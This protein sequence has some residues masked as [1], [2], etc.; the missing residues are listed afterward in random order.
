MMEAL[1]EDNKGGDLARR[2]ANAGGGRGGADDSA[3]RG[4]V[5]ESMKEDNK[6]GDLAR[7]MANAA[8]G[9]HDGTDDSSFRG[10]LF[11]AL[12]KVVGI[13]S[14]GVEDEEH[15]EQ[16]G[17]VVFFHFSRLVVSTL[18]FLHSIF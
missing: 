2:M 6:G 13:S 12:A 5:K 15:E 9:V 14:N 4:M 1:K 17:F 10:R 8:G 3:I 16:V 11:E 18:H 7:R